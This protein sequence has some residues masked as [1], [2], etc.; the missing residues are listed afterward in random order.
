MAI[1]INFD[2]THNPEKPTL[3]L[4]TR[5]GLKLG[6]LRA[7]GISIK[8]CQNDAAE[9]SFEI[10]K[11]VDG[12]KDKL[13]DK[14]KDFRLVWCKEWDVWFEIKVDIDESNET[15]KTVTGIRLG[16]AE[17]S[18]I[19]LYDTH[20]NTEEDI[21]RDDYVP[22]VLFNSL[23]PEGSLLHR[24]L[25]KAEHYKVIHVDP[26]IANI[27]RTFEFDN[28]SIYDAFQE[29]S[30]EIGCLFVFHSNSDENGNIQRTISVYDILSNCMS[31]GHRGEFTN[32]CPECGSLN[33]NEGYGDD[34][35]IF[36]T[37]DELGNEISFTSDTD[38]IKN[39]FK[40]EG[41]DDLMTAT[42]R[43]CNPN[44]TDYIWYITD[45]VK[46]DMSVELVAK[47]ESYD[48]LYQYYQTEYIANLNTTLLSQYNALV[49]KYQNYNSRLEKIKSPIKGYPELMTAY[50]NTVDLA[51]YLETT[52]M[53][54]A[55]L[56]DTSAEKE[57][58]LLTRSNLSP[59]A[60]T[61]LSI[62][63]SATADN[64]VLSM[65]KVIVDSRYQVKIGNSSL[66][67]N[68]WT[69][70][71]VV[72]NY[73]DS[74]DTATSENVSLEISDNYQLYIQQK[75]KKALAKEDI[76]DL[77]I[78]GLFNME[79]VQFCAEIKKYALSS[80][81]RFIDACQSCLDILIEQGVGNA[82]TWSGQDPNLYN[83]LY[84]PYYNKLQALQAEASLRQREIDII[85]G[86]YD[87]DG[88]LTTSGLQTYIDDIKKQIQTALDFE[89]Y[90]GNDLWLEFC[91]YR[92]EDKYSNKNY[93]S[94]GLNNAELFERALEFIRV[95]NEEI[96]KSAELQ[97]SIST[98]LKN[99]LVIK[100]FKP[101]IE[102]FAVGNWLRIQI[103]D[104]V[105][106]LRLLEYEIDYDNIERIT[107]DFS[108]VL[109]TVNGLTDTESVL[110]QA[111][112]MATSYAAT[113][114]QASKGAKGNVLVQ[115]WVDKGLDATNTK[116]IGGADNQT[117]TW[118]SHGML[119]RRYD[120]ITDTYDD[121]QLKIINSTI[122]ITDDNWKN[123]KTAIGSYLYIDPR[124][125]QLVHAYGVNAETLI[126]KLIIGE[127]L[128]IYSENNSLTFDND[129]LKIT[130]GINT[131]TVNPNSAKL[132][133]IS[134][135]IE[136]VLWVDN[137]GKLY[138]KGDGSG[139]DISANDVT[140]ALSSRITQTSDA[141]TSEVARAKKA[142]GDLSDKA[143]GIEE[144]L[145]SKITQT[146]ETIT[147]EV[148]KEIDRA[149]KAE[150]SLSSR[151]TQTS[152]A[153]TS[154]VAK[155][156]DTSE[157][158]S[159]INQSAEKVSIQASKISL[160]GLVTVNSK[161]KVLMDGS[162]EATNAKFSGTV[163]GSTITGSELIFYWTGTNKKKFD[164]KYGGIN[165]YNSDSTYASIQM[166]DNGI[167]FK[168]DVTDGFGH[169]H[170]YNMSNELFMSISCWGLSFDADKAAKIS[171]LNFSGNLS[172]KPSTG[173]LSTDSPISH[174]SNE[175]L[176][177]IF[178]YGVN[179]LKFIYSTNSPYIQFQTIYGAYGI[180]AWYSD[181][182]AKRNI[183][184]SEING[185]DEI[186][187]IPHFQF[188]WKGK[189]E[190]INCG[191]I[192]QDMLSV[193]PQYVLSIKQENGDV[194]Y[195]I[196]EH[197]I[198]PVIT[199]ALQELILKVK[200]LEKEL[201]SVR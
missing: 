63:S 29:I 72:T 64:A 148:T 146:A 42:I 2:S 165:F 186:L 152:D 8:D 136:D 97:H 49:E 193:N 105:Y 145:S 15:T 74:E 80:L 112:S 58:K 150:E 62:V 115:N 160:E 144:T 37:A 98:S 107:V 149:T 192:A 76:N 82:Q 45:D 108:D 135:E 95:A 154:E 117:Q 129:G 32:K 178:G 134:N 47:L 60:V 139:L 24:L 28:T 151:I 61:N 173:I 89:K 102:H 201:E 177:A 197:T 30:E 51:T 104:V 7:K 99:L 57:A 94:D 183:D 16:V 40:L 141:I 168:S 25:K 175:L 27:Q 10:K 187:K 143:D 138:I 3:V 114:R 75:I 21:E 5:S 17:L 100:K 59:V 48:K 176:F 179:K 44:G 79:Y 69:G 137:F 111:K 90:L 110:S 93:I 103:D 147:S 133:S 91:T 180:T 85:F 101:L 113:Q 132:L 88:N 181:K 116:I 35:T 184:I 4:A 65:A 158:I 194:S 122:S 185:I 169:L 170:Y 125:G 157:I 55:A 20:I 67:H 155:K 34:T 191:Y 86:V 174:Y 14:I 163:S 54:D 46:E 23:K 131:F 153:I 188:D 109:K 127:S 119:F 83:N 53:P 38:A 162:I 41:G 123:V 124:T 68:T 52:L 198:I 6:G 120:A 171:G 128:G 70:N 31:C 92:R 190:H 196:N 1:K 164:I 50:Y 156:V 18:Q 66:N 130:N 13:W 195:Q 106:K 39:C 36:I 87:V 78:V 166:I 159:K 199:K 84:V 77:S 200:K 96:Y 12:K 81:T 22:T 189:N 161:F 118:D 19:M 26:T 126:G 11:Y 182:R 172:I 73:S 142:E 167:S 43:N 121:I 9:I 140:N 71:F 56:D 33:I